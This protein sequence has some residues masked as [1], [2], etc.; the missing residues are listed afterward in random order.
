MAIFSIEDH[1][2]R[3]KYFLENHRQA[4][5]MANSVETSRFY[6]N[7]MYQ[8][9]GVI[10]ARC[11]RRKSGRFAHWSFRLRRIGNTSKVDNYLHTGLL[12]LSIRCRGIKCLLANQLECR[13][14]W[15]VVTTTAIYYK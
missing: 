5:K 1:L 12:K 7:G 13:Q 3:R 4:V 11:M 14:K 6:N 8:W 2:F 10:E 9:Y 15:N